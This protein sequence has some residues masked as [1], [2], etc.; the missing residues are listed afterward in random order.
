MPGID[1]VELVNETRS[2]GYSVRH[3]Q[4]WNSFTRFVMAEAHPNLTRLL[5]PE[6]ELIVRMSV[7]TSPF[8]FTDPQLC[9]HRPLPFTPRAR[10]TLHGLKILSSSRSIMR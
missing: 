2:T 3:K 6:T 7:Q 4:F 10:D 5:P 8:P 9:R 1:K